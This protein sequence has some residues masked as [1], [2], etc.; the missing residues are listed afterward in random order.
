MDAGDEDVRV[1]LRAL[2]M[3]RFKSVA[4]GG[5]HGRR[6]HELQCG[7]PGRWKAP[8]PTQVS[9]RE[10]RSGGRRRGGQKPAGRRRGGEQPQAVPVPLDVHGHVVGAARRRRPQ[11]VARCI[12]RAVPMGRRCGEGDVATPLAAQAARHTI[13]EGSHASGS[14]HHPAAALAS[15]AVARRV[16]IGGSAVPR[17]RSRHA[18]PRAAATA[19]AALAAAS[20]VAAA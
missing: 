19:D 4:R 12:P 13:G 6:L 18:L 1:Q 3:A 10:N 16:L 14:A 15:Q 7:R 9:R 17:L 5:G 2:W 8:Q 11:T 20:L